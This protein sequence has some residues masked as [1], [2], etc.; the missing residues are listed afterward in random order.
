MLEDIDK[1]LG[2]LIVD[3]QALTR[4]MVKSIIRQLGFANLY[5]AE[6]GTRA[7]EILDTNKIDL[8]ICDWNMP[9]MKGIEVLRAIKNNPKYKKVKFVML[10]AEAYRESVKEAMNLKVDGYIAKPFT[11]KQLEESLV[12]VLRDN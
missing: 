10:T 5:L 7:M 6:N 8:I 1:N 9:R 2:V 3:D 12:K 4:D 11:A